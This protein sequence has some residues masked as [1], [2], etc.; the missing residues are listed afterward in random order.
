MSLSDANSLQTNVMESGRSGGKAVRMISRSAKSS[1]F[2]DIDLD[3][4]FKDETHFLPT[5]ILVRMR[6]AWICLD[7]RSLRIE[8]VNLLM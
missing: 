1:V 2:A 7:D 6:G 4:D 8:S 5:F 3:S